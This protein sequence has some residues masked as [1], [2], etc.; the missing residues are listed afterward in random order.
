MSDKE[1]LAMCKAFD[2]SAE[3]DKERQLENI[4]TRLKQEERVIMNKNRRLKRPVA[5]II[6]AVV[7]ITSLSVVALAGIPALVRHLDTRIIEGE[8]YIIHF[9]AH[10]TDDGGILMGIQWAQTQGIFHTEILPTERVVV[11]IDGEERV[12]MDVMAMDN[13][14][15]ALSLFANPH[16][17][18]PTY[19]PEGFEFY[20]AIFNICPCRNANNRNASRD[21]SINFHKAH[22]T[23][24][25]TIIHFHNE[26]TWELGE[27]TEYVDINGSL[28][29]FADGKLTF[30]INDLHYALTLSSLYDNLDEAHQTLIRIA[31][32]I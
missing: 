10:E 17:P 8:N 26:I 19:L 32:S 7:A 25:L 24:N 11:E 21:I 1:F 18:L 31:K 5:A 20:Q 23:F 9:E 4:K 27:N 2:P 6:A 22:D 16:A 13:L 12:L 29:S 30:R 15:Y 28:A 14:D 3:V